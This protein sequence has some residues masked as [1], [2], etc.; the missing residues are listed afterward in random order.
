ML[1]LRVSRLDVPLAMNETVSPL[2]RMDT[3]IATMPQKSPFGTDARLPL[4]SRL[5]PGNFP[6]LPAFRQAVDD[7]FVVGA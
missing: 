5:A 3:Q 7:E 2:R 6:Q 4:F 1:V